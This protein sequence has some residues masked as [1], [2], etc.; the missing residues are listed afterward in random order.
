MV[1]TSADSHAISP[2]PERHCC[3]CCAIAVS[4]LEAAARSGAGT[5][6]LAKNPFPALR[7]KHRT[8]VICFT[9]CPIDPL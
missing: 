5:N 3:V 8:N 2:F 4:R 9:N 6:P 7:K 1:P